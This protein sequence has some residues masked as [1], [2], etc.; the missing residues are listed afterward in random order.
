MLQVGAS[1]AAV[2]VA[3]TLEILSY[4][5]HGKGYAQGEYDKY[6]DVLPEHKL[7]RKFVCVGGYIA[8]RITAND[9]FGFN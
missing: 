1:L 2:L 4:A 6:D 9:Q 5:M 8:S 7:K 3:A